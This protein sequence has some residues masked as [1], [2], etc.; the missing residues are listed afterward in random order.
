MKVGIT[1]GG[2]GKGVELV[3]FSDSNFGADQDDRRPIAGY[4]FTVNGGTIL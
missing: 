2:T 1:F 4:V 3:G